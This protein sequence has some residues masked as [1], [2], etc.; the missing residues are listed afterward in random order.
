MVV[1]SRTSLDDEMSAGARLLLT[2]E[3]TAASLPICRTKVSE[4]LRNGQLESIRIGASR[5][6][7]SAALAEYVQRLRDEQRVDPEMS[8]TFGHERRP[9]SDMGTIGEVRRGRGAR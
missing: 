6:I 1:G 7:P 3:Q 4:L 5:R 2:A 8:W 9:F